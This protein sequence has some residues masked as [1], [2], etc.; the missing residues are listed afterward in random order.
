M[1]KIMNRAEFE[2]N[3]QIKT[4]EKVQTERI[5]DQATSG[6][7]QKALEEER[8]LD[9]QLKDMENLGRYPIDRSI[10]DLLYIIFSHYC[11]LLF[12]F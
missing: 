5:I 1:P 3:E 12:L 10:N 4:I 9:A 6:I 7:L 8:A 2:R 11:L